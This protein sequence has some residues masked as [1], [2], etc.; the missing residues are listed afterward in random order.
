MVANFLILQNSL[1]GL[2]FECLRNV[3]YDKAKDAEDQ[4]NHVYPCCSGCHMSGDGERPAA[5]A[6]I[7]GV[8]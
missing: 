1:G 2:L 8:I 7:L 3:A 4:M 5:V 6:L